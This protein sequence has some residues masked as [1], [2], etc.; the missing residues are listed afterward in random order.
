MVQF[1]TLV[2][3]SAALLPASETVISQGPLMSEPVKVSTTLPLLSSTIRQPAPAV[4]DVP[5]VVGKLPTIT[6]PLCSTTS[7]VVKPTPPGHLP[8]SVLALIWAKT[9]TVFTSGET[10]MI[11]VPVPLCIAPLLILLNKI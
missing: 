9:F 2:T 1:N 10:S 7:A 8:G 6:Q 5:S 4:A 3:K 11:V